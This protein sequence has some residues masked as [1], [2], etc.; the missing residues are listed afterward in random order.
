MHPLALA[1]ATLLAGVDPGP[2]T[3]LAWKELAADELRPRFG[4]QWKADLG[5]FELLA[6]N[7][8]EWTRPL[9]TADG[10]RVFVGSTKGRLEAREVESGRLLWKRDDMG[11]IGADMVEFRRLVVVG[12]DSDAVALGKVRGTEVWR[13]PLGSRIGGAVTTTGT[14]AV[15]PIRPNGFVA[16]DLEAGERLWQVKRATPEGLTIRGQA[17]AVVDAQ[18]GLVFLGFSDG[19]LVAVRLNDGSTAWV[20]SL[21]KSGEFFSDVDALA[22]LPDGDLLAAS[23]N[24]GLYRMD[25]SNGAIRWQRET[26]TRIV[27]LVAT[28]S[29]RILA[30]EG[31]GQVLGLDPAK[32]SVRW[33]YRME[34][35]APSLAALLPEG[36]A[37][38]ASSRGPAV[39]LATSNGRP[40]QLVAPGPGSS[41]APRVHGRSLFIYS[42]GGL[43]LALRENAPSGVLVR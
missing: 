7:K 37:A 40:L 12:S 24:S 32:G 8:E 29:G 5:T 17:G 27:G 15:F 3:S 28:P 1:L 35:G 34:K 43:L 21:G 41:V 33:R 38:I 26:L 13:V 39:I 36:R 9:V 22:R 25:P 11:A 6:T 20:A 23:Y 4:V 10:A 31:E 19:A 42:N 2:T 18:R 30:S 14:V 16:V